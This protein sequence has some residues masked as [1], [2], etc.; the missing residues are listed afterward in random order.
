MTANRPYRAARPVDDA[1]A[2]LARC[3]GR[4]FDRLCVDGLR[5]ALAKTP[6]LRMP[7]AD[8]ERRATNLF[9]RTQVSAA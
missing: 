2:E 8:G 7:A 4:Q 6:S 9:A 1:V 3:A 5:T